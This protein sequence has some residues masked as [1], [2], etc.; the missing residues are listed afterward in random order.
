M[1]T[2]YGIRAKDSDVYFY[3]G[4]TKFSPDKRL[5]NHL[6]YIKGGLNKNRHFTNK[7]NQ[8]GF[9]NLIIETLV[10]CG[11]SERWALEDKWIDKLRIEGHPL[12]NLA[13]NKDYVQKGRAKVY[14]PRDMRSM[15]ERKEAAAWLIDL[16][17]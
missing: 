5:K 14:V 3:V 8:V 10:E 2:I 17:I 1:I 16:P 12:T 7:V 9:D 4:S 11:E 15:E 6:Q 13:M